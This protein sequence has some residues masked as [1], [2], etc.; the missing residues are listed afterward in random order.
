MLTRRSCPV[1]VPRR[2][3]GALLG[4][5]VLG[6]LSAGSVSAQVR[7][8]FRPAENSRQVHRLETSAK[9]VLTIN[10][11]EISSGTTQFIVTETTNGTRAADRT[12]KSAVRITHLQQE[13]DINGTKLAFDSGNPD[14]KAEVAQ[15]EPILDILR[16]IAKA[17]YTFV[18]DAKNRVMKVEGT[19]KV[20]KAVSEELRPQL[21]DQFNSKS[22]AKAQN[23]EIAR[24]PDKPVKPGDT[25]ERIETMTFEAGQVMTFGVVYTY[26][27]TLEQNGK[28]LHRIT[29][30]H[31]TVKYTQETDL[32]VPVKIT[33]SMLKV[34]GT[35]G[36]LL[37]D[38]AN[39]D[40]ISSKMKV[41]MK[42]T[43]TL[44]INGQETKGD[45]D[46]TIGVKS[47]L[48]LPGG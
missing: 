46:L 33:G 31:L 23:E 40:V 39:N 15:L 14:K 18:Y 2:T 12:L 28:T 22:L 25:W 19:D 6:T 32:P 45:L 3:S 16:V 41:R 47:Q 30:K 48:Q 38:P 21:K 5:L 42:G 35:K 17:R 36:T 4:M 34:V 24:L 11:M 7:M 43:L 13:L 10:G 8:T 29:K 26:A 37:Y 9:Q 44:D 27:G 20:L 1:T